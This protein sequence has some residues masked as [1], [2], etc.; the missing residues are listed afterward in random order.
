MIKKLFEIKGREIKDNIN[1]FGINL[2]DKRVIID[3]NEINICDNDNK[4]ELSINKK[5]AD[6]F[7]KV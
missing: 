3:G 5:E 7:Q 1:I 4:L 6:I 2:K